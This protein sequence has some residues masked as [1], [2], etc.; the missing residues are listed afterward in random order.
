MLR[1]RGNRIGGPGSPTHLLRRHT[2]LLRHDQQA[3][4]TQWG[5][6]ET[7]KLTIK[8]HHLV[9]L[10]RCLH[11]IDFLR[12]HEAERLDVH[13]GFMEINRKSCA[14]LVF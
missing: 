11:M 13:S 7:T 2:M 9:C 6:A 4:E 12:H 1:R 5:K 8:L 10:G 3:S 14:S